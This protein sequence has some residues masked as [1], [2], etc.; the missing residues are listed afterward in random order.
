LLKP[1]NH[2]EDIKTAEKLLKVAWASPSIK[3]FAFSVSPEE[4][5]ISSCAFAVFSSF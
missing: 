2:Q 3:S 5:S 1:A 4:A